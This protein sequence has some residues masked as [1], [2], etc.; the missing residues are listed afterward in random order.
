MV[1]LICGKPKSGKTTYGKYLCRKVG[2]AIHLDSDE[3]RKIFDY[4]D[5]S[6]NGRKEWM[7]RMADLASLLEKQGFIP[8]ISM[9]APYRNTRKEM[10]KKFEKHIL[11]YMKGSDRYMW[12]GSM[13][14]EPQDDENPVVKSL[15]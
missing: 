12:K 2:S 10:V 15:K 14:E 6:E 1:V 3:L 5:F 11:I 9:V 13:F 4:D 7:L 8:I